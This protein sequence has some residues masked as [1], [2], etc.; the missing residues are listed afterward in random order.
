MD[1]APINLYNARNQNNAKVSFKGY[2]SSI[3]KRALTTTLR[4]IQ[5]DGQIE[6]MADDWWRMLAEMEQTYSSDRFIDVITYI[7]DE[8]VWAK[9]GLSGGRELDDFVIKQVSQSITLAP[10]KMK[11]HVDNYASQARNSPT[12]GLRGII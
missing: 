7:E 6:K 5:P 2:N 3:T 9:L 1:V 4:K 8:N 12:K 11:N 10:Q